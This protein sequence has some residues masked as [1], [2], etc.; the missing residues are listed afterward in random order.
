MSVSHLHALH[1]RKPE[2]GIESREAR[3][4]HSCWESAPGPLEEQTV[5]LTT[6]VSYQV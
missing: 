2:E 3:V 4:T 6:A 1:P 5:L